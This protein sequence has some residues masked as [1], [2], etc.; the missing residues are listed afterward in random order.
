MDVFLKISHGNYNRIIKDK[1]QLIDVRQYTQR[2][3]RKEL[4]MCPTGTWESVSGQT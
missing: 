2:M 4:W 3:K 1:G